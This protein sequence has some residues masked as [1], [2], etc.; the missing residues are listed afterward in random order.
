[1]AKGKVAALGYY[2]KFLDHPDETI[3]EDAFLEFARS[4]DEEVGQA[5]KKLQP[6][7][8]R[9]LLQNS[10]ID[11]D[12][13]SLFAFLLGCCGDAADAA[14]LKGRIEQARGDDLR[15]LDGL[16]GGYI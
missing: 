12:R 7:R 11:P 10:K 2:A 13:V 3:A 1:R 15:A 14:F 8:L 5:A 16:L 6:A 4:G 9:A